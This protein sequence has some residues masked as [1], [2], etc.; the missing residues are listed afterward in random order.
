MPI[1][2][3]NI[4]WKKESYKE[5]HFKDVRIEIDNGEIWL[6]GRMNSADWHIFSSAYPAYVDFS[7]DIKKYFSFDNAN[8]EG[9][10]VKVKLDGAIVSY[11]RF[12][13]L[14]DL[15]EFSFKLSDITY[16]YQ[17]ASEESHIVLDLSFFH[18]SG[19]LSNFKHY[20]EDIIINKNDKEYRLC[21]FD[22]DNRTML[23]GNI[24]NEDVVKDILVHLAFYFN[25]LPN[26][27][28]KSINKDGET[29]VTNHTSLLSSSN[30]SLYHS[31]LPYITFGEKHC[32]EYFFTKSIWSNLNDENKQK[33]EN[34]I[35]TFARCKYCDDVTQ[36]LLLYSILDR[37][38]GNSK[39]TNP[40]PQM[41]A[42]LNKYNIDIAKIGEST[43]KCLQKMK[44]KMER[45]G[46]KKAGVSNFCHLRSYIL[47]FMSNSN[48]EKY[49]TQSGIVDRMRFAATVIILNELGFQNVH[50]YKDWQHLSVLYN[51]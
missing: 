20:P 10:I 42:N 45:S 7:A 38:A 14:R 50:F 9:K 31:E 22:I 33:M 5:L 49:V 1:I 51:N 2:K 37:F 47:H 8:I 40:Y 48:I 30:E 39:D 4:V 34:A 12:N 18:L 28:E 25:M 13:F 11:R 27:F 32:F 17:C 46:G 23:I 19:K 35:Y 26:I 21:P 44:L 43:D 15:T 36:F 3:T 41:K 24:D 6:K 16:S 29:H